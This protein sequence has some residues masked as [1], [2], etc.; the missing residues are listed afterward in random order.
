MRYAVSFAALVAGA[1]SQAT[2]EPADFNVTEALLDNGVN[3][4]AIPELAPLAERSLLSG[5][6]IA[7]NSLKLI[8][9]DDQVET[10][11]ESAYSAFVGAYWSAQQRQLSPQCVF[12]PKKALDISTSILL[13]RLTQ[14][15]F[16]AKSGG[17][18]AV[19]G[20]SNI[21]GGITISFENMSKTTVSSDK[22]SVSFEPGQT[23][24]DVYT[25]LE[26]DNVTIIGGRVSSVGVGG[27]T[28]G[29]GISYF[30]SEYGLACD[31]VLAYELVTASGLIINVSEKSFPD[32]YW[33]LR[34]GGNN[35]GLV[36][37]FTVNAIPRAPT[38]WGGMRTHLPTNFTALTKAYYNLGM[39]ANKDGKAHQI[40]SFGWGRPN[41][42]PV[43]QL[44]LEY[45]DPIAD[46]PILAEYNSI[47]GAI[48]D[49]TGVKSLSTLTSILAGPATGNGLR[50]GFW[51][52]TTT[53]D[54]E[55]AN[56]A[57]DIFFE[58]LPSI[59]DAAAIIPA[60]S[61]QVITEPIIEQSA[62]RGGNPLGLDPKEGP[63][64][65][66]L[67]SLKWSDPADDERLNTFARTVQDRSSAAAKAAGKMNDYLY[68]NYASP[69]QNVVAGYGA[70]NQAKLKTISKK[71]DPTGVFETLQPGYFKLDGTPS[72]EF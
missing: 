21:E 44:E 11:S 45:S 39:N 50:Q 7:C 58:E 67:V 41:L 59:M 65:L 61:L 57:R 35:F 42:G 9:G 51:T 6:S 49:G 24:Y 34:G 66:A 48:A 29:G 3:V 54:L 18:S 63:L 30:S 16:A 26:K 32:L 72:G 46:A 13:A 47:K 22:K 4:S 20:G 40:L 27:L 55:M 52:W 38:M 5:C 15:P 14:C 23:W 69:Y 53:L 33:A 56:T 62:K 70:A 8:F 28:L 60:L 31:N 2:F 64:M 37:K 17:H 19:A 71:Y 25:A 1:V 43:A 36:T 10:R 68:M 12:K